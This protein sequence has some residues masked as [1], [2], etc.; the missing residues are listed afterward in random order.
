MSVNG[1]TTL[2]I[3]TVSPEKKG[4]FGSAFVLPLT[5]DGR[6][7]LT[8]EKRGT[9]V[10]YGM[11]GGSARPEETDFQCMSRAAKEESGGALSLVTI[12]RISEGRG[13]INAAKVYYENSRSYAVKHDL[14]H[15]ADLNVTERFE[16]ENVKTM[17]ASRA[18]IEKKKTKKRATTKRAA[19]QLGLEFV[20]LYS[21]RSWE[22][23][24]KHMHHVA[25]VLAA[26]LTKLG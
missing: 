13:I 4:S 10:K 18:T 16:P 21:L 5:R 1:N 26:R 15:H 8:K 20:P 6:V 23:R 9:V 24:G 14:V 19:E 3:R 17:R 7:L 2:N 25:S 22:W 11:L 12:A